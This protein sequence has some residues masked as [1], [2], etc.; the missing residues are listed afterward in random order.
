MRRLLCLVYGLVAYLLFLASWAAFIGFLS[1]VGVPA[2]NIETLSTADLM[3]SLADE[4]VEEVGLD[5]PEGRPAAMVRDVIAFSDDV[6]FVCDVGSLEEVSPRTMAANWEYSET[7]WLP[8]DAV[9]QFDAGSAGEI[10]AATRAL[11]RVLAWVKD[12]E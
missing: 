12:G 7:M 1:G 3:R 9:A 2:A 8:V 11:F 4:V 6:A 10:I 5:L